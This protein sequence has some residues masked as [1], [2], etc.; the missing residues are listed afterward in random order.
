MRALPAETLAVV[1]CRALDRSFTR[2]QLI[3]LALGFNLIAWA[4]CMAA[5]RIF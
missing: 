1:A 3:G 2:A 4:A 5:M